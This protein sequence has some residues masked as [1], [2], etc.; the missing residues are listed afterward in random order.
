[1]PWDANFVH[2]R[3]E[4]GAM[5]NHSSLADPYVGGSPFSSPNHSGSLP[6]CAAS[7]K[8]SVHST[9]SPTDTTGNGELCQAPHLPDLVHTA[10]A[11][12]GMLEAFKRT[13]QL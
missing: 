10:F 3:L 8:P 5:S 9:K 13:V 4:L 6:N 11:N 7:P 12:E 2:R 1:M